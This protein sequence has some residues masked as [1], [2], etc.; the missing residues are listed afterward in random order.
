MGECPTFERA[1]WLY[2]Y[3]CKLA[4]AHMCCTEE[5][6]KPEGIERSSPEMQNLR[7]GNESIV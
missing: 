4:R 2:M 1:W 3:A 6:H 5:Q 7:R